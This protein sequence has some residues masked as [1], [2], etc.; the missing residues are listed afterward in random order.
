MLWYFCCLYI[1]SQMKHYIHSMK[2]VIGCLVFTMAGLDCMNWQIIIS[3]NMLHSFPSKR[4]LL[5][6][7]IYLHLLCVLHTVAKM[8]LW[9]ALTVLSNPFCIYS[10][11]MPLGV[12][13]ADIQYYNMDVIHSVLMGH[14]YF[15]TSNYLVIQSCNLVYGY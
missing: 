11:N 13:D 9:L 12:N 3:Y 8:S 4:A 6:T 2:I 15:E 7:I 5:F 1:G 14:S 10:K